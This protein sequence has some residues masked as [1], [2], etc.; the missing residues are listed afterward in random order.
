M[1]KLTA[2]PNTPWRYVAVWVVLPMRIVL[3]S[4]AKPLFPMKT[5]FEPMPLA[6][7]ALAPMAMLSLAEE[8]KPIGVR[9]P[10]PMAVLLLPVELP[11]SVSAPT[12]VFAAPLA[13]SPSDDR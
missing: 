3:L 13:M 7:P 2:W 4:A 10:N 6:D 12:A 1:V 11:P 9:A 8:G 5:L